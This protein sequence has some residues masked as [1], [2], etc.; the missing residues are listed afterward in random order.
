MAVHPHDP[1]E[2][3]DQRVVARQVA[4]DRSGTKSAECIIKDVGVHR[5]HRILADAD[6]IGN[7]RPHALQQD[8]GV[9]CKRP[10][11]LATRYGPQIEHD[12]AF[13][14]VHVAMDDARPVDFGCPGAGVVAGG[15]LDLHNVRTELGKDHRCIRPRHVRGKIG[16]PDAFKRGKSCA[17]NSGVGSA[18]IYHFHPLAFLD[19]LL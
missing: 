18:G 14:G 2:R 11:G 8:V 1:G 10:C 5:T 6:S 12:T 3:L 19:I 16:N 9:R 17:A 13:P 7:T 4:A 15:G